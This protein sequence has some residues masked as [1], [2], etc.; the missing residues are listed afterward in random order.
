MYSLT[1]GTVENPLATFE[2]KGLY[3]DNAVR[4]RYKLHISGDISGLKLVVRS[5]SLGKTWTI[6]AASFKKINNTSDYYV[7][8]AGLNFNQLDEVVTAV[9]QD[10]AGNAVSETMTYSIGSY[11][12]N[13]IN[14]N[15]ASPA[16]VKLVA[17]LKTLA[18]LNKSATDFVEAAS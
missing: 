15:D 8:F 18:K 9:V 4:I 17:L 10:A 3:L 5:E 16:Q 12:Y 11:I 6:R 7:Y 1:T 14:K 2:G 13:Q